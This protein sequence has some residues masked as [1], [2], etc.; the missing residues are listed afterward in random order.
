M[1]EL[2]VDA[3]VMI[4]ISASGVSIGELANSNQHL[5]LMAKNAANEA[6][7]VVSDDNGVLEEIDLRRYVQANELSIVEL[8]QH[9]LETFVKLTRQVDDGEAATL[10]MSIHRRWPIATDDRK[11]QR[12]ALA[13]NPPL[14]LVTTSSLMRGWAENQSIPKEQVHEVLRGIER[15]ASYVPGASDPCQSWWTDQTSS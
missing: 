4:N 1:R 14:E 12:L 6:M 9:E 3:C 5:F 2:L 13:T 11:A 15:R 7:Y 8:A 10:A